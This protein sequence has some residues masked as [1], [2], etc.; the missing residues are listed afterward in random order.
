MKILL[1]LSFLS[2]GAVAANAQGVSLDF[3]DPTLQMV[4]DNGLHPY[5]VPGAEDQRLGFTKGDLK[6]ILPGRKPV[7]LRVYNGSM[8][9]WADYRISLFQCTGVSQPLGEGAATFRRICK[10]WGVTPNGFDEAAASKAGRPYFKGFL[11]DNLTVSIGFTPLLGG[12]RKPMSSVYVGISLNAPGIDRN[13]LSWKGPIQAPPGYEKV[14]LDPPASA[15]GLIKV[16]KVIPPK[17]IS[18]GPAWNLITS[19]VWIF[20]AA[21]VVLG[22]VIGGWIRFRKA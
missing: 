8:N 4:L 12:G 10:A 18:K 5:R 9:V 20:V 17:P 13:L 15:E 16:A 3:D 14:S 1:L 6:I 21:L 22:A 11:V 7:E 19:S 2:L